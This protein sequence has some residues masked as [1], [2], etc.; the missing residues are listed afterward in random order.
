MARIKVAKVRQS[1]TDSNEN[2]KTICA[3]F[4]YYYNQYK[5]DE[6]L[7]LPIKTL[8]RMLSVARKE[9]AKEYM[10]LA[11]IARVAQ[12]TKN[13]PYQSLVKQYEQE[14]K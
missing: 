3:T 14:A 7:E 13:A 1:P 9:K 8:K 2:L 12:S 10:Q 5:Y 4:C 6:A 11:Q